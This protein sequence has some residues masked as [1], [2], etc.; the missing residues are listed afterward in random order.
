M[1]GKTR[2][3]GGIWEI[4]EKRKIAESRDRKKVRAPT[5]KKF[6][7]LGKEIEKRGEEGEWRVDWSTVGRKVLGRNLFFF[8]G[9]KIKNLPS[10]SKLEFF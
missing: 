1:Q 3:F 8:L 9:Q 10:I 6:P 7:T 5:K 2:E 4:F